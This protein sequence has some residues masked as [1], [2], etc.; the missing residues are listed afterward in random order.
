MTKQN[1][2]NISTCLWFDDQAEEVAN[3]YMSV[4]ENANILDTTLN[5]VETPSDKPIGSV[6]TVDFEID[7]YS[8]TALNGGPHFTPNPSIS[9]FVNCQTDKEVDRLW[10]ELSDEGNGHVCRF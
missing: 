4:F 5:Q 3:F 7:G 10:E 9:F 6:M 2:N 1:T 8:F